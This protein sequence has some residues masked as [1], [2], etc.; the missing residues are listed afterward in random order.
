MKQSLPVDDT[1]VGP[2]QV[3]DNGLDFLRQERSRQARDSCN[4]TMAAMVHA[5]LSHP[6]ARILQLARPVER[7]VL[8]PRIQKLLRDVDSLRAGLQISSATHRTVTPKN[9]HL[10]LP[11]LELVEAISQKDCLV[12]LEHLV[13][14]PHPQWIFCLLCRLDN[15]LLSGHVHLLR[16]L[17]TLPLEEAPLFAAI[18][19]HCFGQWDLLQK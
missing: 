13:A 16:Q 2:D 7:P 5:K 1:F 17:A 6:D 19:A 3:V 15:S 11:T 10:K 4:T 18:V 9:I 14:N 8:H 12:L